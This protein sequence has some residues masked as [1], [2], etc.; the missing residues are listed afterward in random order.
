MPN[1]SELNVI[2]IV[3]ARGGSKGIENKN[4]VKLNNHPLISYSI[5]AGMD[6]KWVDRVICSTDSTE[7]ANIAEHYGAEV[8][9]MRPSEYATDESRDIAVFQHLNE[10]LQTDPDLYVHLRPTSPLRYEGQIDSA[11]ETF[12][13]Q[14]DYFDSARSVTSPSQNPFKMWQISQDEEL[15]PLMT[16]PEIHEPHNAPRQILP[17]VWWQTGNLDIIKKVTI[18]NFESMTG[19]R[20]MPLRT[21]PEYAI[22]IDTIDDL[23]YCEIHM[24]N[25]E[26][27]I[28]KISVY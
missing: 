28:P 14:Y 22:D 9:F 25:L 20:I 16:H 24:E 26:C 19:E 18:K 2:A 1:I 13:N 17:H 21:P 11:L 4:I 27:L 7:I 8:P 3:P 10:N 6:A 23:R 5:C 12:M 15:V